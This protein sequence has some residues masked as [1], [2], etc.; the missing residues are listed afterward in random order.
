MN[1]RWKIVLALVILLPVVYG[2]T[3]LIRYKQ[4]KYSIE[5]HKIVYEKCLP[6][7]YVNP[8]GINRSPSSS[9]FND[10]PLPFSECQTAGS[11]TH[12]LLWLPEYKSGYFQKS[13]INW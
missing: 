10:L 7:L 2:S 8:G 5:Q 12:G 13:T 6:K 3:Y 4:V 11:F 9:S 1:A